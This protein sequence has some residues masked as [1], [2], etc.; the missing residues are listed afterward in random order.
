LPAARA[1]AGLGGALDHPG[2]SNSLRASL[3]AIDEVAASLDGPSAAAGPAVKATGPQGSVRATDADQASQGWAA[4]APMDFDTAAREMAAHAGSHGPAAQP[5]F[6]MQGP[7]VPARSP[8][9]PFAHDPLLEEAA[10]RFANGD[11]QSAEEAMKSAAVDA[12][13]LGPDSSQ[14]V[15]EALF[16]L[17]RATGQLDRFEAATLEYASVL[18]RSPPPWVSLPDRLAQRPARSAAPVR[19]RVPTSTR[20]GKLGDAVS[21]ST[22]AQGVGATGALSDDQAAEAFAAQA[23]WRAPARLT[24][25]SLTPLG[26]SPVGEGRVIHVDWS[27][28][29]AIDDAAAPGLARLLSL[30]CDS[31]VQVRLAG[32]EQLH[33]V[34]RER[35]PSGQVAVAPEWW[36]LRLDALRLIGRVPDFEDAALEY[37]MTFEVSPPQWQ[38][39]RCQCVLVDPE[40]GDTMIE[41]APSRIDSGA[42]VWN[43]STVAMSHDDFVLDDLSADLVGILQGE[44]SDSIESLQAA[45]EGTTTLQVRCELLLRVDFAAAGAL[46]NWAAAAQ[47]NGQRVHFVGLHRLV[48]TF[49]NVIGIN[50]SATVSIRVD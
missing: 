20:S 6:G 21:A 37:C 12:A 3:S 32:G 48:A 31:A 2:V 29:Q 44:I 8:L 41:A 7:A 26:L 24:S 47:G 42:S 43:A 30:W 46:L 10:I 18:S 40:S 23:A 34:L 33:A 17:Y 36:Q 5:G 14:A 28:L 35:T 15:W 1:G 16:D 27:A 45:A 49:F 19:K 39:P 4:T 11:T 25:A 13:L 9:E 50:E 22:A 38:A